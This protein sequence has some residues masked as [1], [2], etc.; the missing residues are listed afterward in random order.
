MNNNVLALLAGAVAAVLIDYL[1]KLML[2]VRPRKALLVAVVIGTIVFAVVSTWFQSSSSDATQ[3]SMKSDCQID[4]GQIEI[5]SDIVE[6]K[7]IINASIQANNPNKRPLLYTWSASKGEMEPA[8]RSQSSSSSYRAPETPD[9]VMIFVAIGLPDCTTIT[10]SRLIAVVMPNATPIIPTI[11]PTP[12]ADVTKKDRDIMLVIDK[13]ASMFSNQASTSFDEVKNA[14]SIMVDALDTRDRLGVVTFSSDSL[15][16]SGLT[17]DKSFLKNRIESIS[18]GGGETLLHLG[19][20]DAYAE[21]MTNGRPGARKMIVVVTDGIPTDGEQ[22]IAL[23]DKIKSDNIEITIL[24]VESTATSP[25]LDMLKFFTTAGTNAFA[26]REA[27]NLPAMLL[28][29]LN[30]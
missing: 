4:A 8:F 21:L 29:I 27:A 28:Q 20:K 10:R 22:P 12:L 14:T 25:N 3:I 16:I 19:L 18:H 9:D 5:S 24:F 15:L 30:R 13:S 1:I 2:P 26:A 7:G 23:A 17:G 11:T 6:I